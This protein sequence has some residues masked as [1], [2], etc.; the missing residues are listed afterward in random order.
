MIRAYTIMAEIGCIERFRSDKHLASYSLP[1]PPVNETG[2][3]DD[4]YPKGRHVGFAGRRTLK[5]AFIEAAHAAIR[6][7]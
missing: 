1:V 2:D 6:F 5:W 3:P 4:E 7:T